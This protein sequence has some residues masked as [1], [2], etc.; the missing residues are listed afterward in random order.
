MA[1]FIIVGTHDFYG[2]SQREIVV[3]QMVVL[4]S[5]DEKR[6][7]YFATRESA[8]A[9]IADLDGERYDLMHNESNRPDY[10]VE[11]A[12]YEANL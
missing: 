2:P 5:G 10:R 12:A 9:F 8:E 1:K 6:I 4:S 7:K 11:D 3:D